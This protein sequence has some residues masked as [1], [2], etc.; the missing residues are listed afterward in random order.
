MLFEQIIANNPSLQPYE[1]I[2]TEITENGNRLVLHLGSRKDTEEE[3]CPHC[4]A[5]SYLRQL[6]HEAQGYAALFRDET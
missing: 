6:Q 5:C 4:V 1:Y 3:R 2:S